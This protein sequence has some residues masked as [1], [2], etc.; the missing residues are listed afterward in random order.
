MRCKKGSHLGCIHVRRWGPVR[1]AMPLQGCQGQV[2]LE[3][4]NLGGRR[5]VASQ[6]AP[7][8]GNPGL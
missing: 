6:G 2:D 1:T 5:A 7:I 4:L 3:G 8:L